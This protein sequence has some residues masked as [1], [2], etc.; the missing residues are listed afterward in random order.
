[1]TL[2]V[3]FFFGEKREDLWEY[4]YIIND[5][6]PNVDKNIKFISFDTLNE[7]EQKCDVF[8]Y[9]CRDP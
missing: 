6:L 4:D 7:T 5:L 1:M 2:S 8:V 9:S 3:V